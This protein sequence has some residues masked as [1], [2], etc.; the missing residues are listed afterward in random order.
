L[1]DYDEQA[2]G[3]GMVLT[4]TGEILTNNHVI[5]GAT[6]ISVTDIGNG[7]T[8]SATVV[9]YDRSEDVAV[10]QL[11]DASGLKTVDL[12]N[13]ATAA[14]GEG[15]VGIGNAGGVG[16]APSVAGG[17]ITALGQSI[18]ASDEGDGTSEK[19][20]DLIETNCDIQPGDS[21]GPLVNSQGQV[22]G[23]D[24]AASEASSGGGFYFHTPT[25]QTAANQ[26]YAIPI[27]TAL[28]L[29]KKIEAGQASTTVHI[30]KTAFL[31]VN[32]A[33][34]GTTSSSSTGRLGFGF[35][36]SSTATATPSAATTKGA[37]IVGVVAG[38]PAAAAG[39]AKGDVIIGFAG[40]T[41]TSTTALTSTIE[42]YHPGSR[43]KVTW[44]TS[45]GQTQSAT[46][47][48]ATGPSA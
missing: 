5:E 11:K 1:K 34:T 39:I 10:I 41:I 9:G 48:L 36:T 13:S 7:K 29:A 44:V 42:S 4:S 6:T 27:D 19:L 18:T 25:G 22:L 30:G 16:G 17:S 21:G 26:G 35:G 46:V 3:T 12:G 31:G 14:K 45:S 23:M 43:V 40:K 47:T 33:P 2:A 8:Y 38:D 37:R 28:T 15:V 32:V 24:T 20:T